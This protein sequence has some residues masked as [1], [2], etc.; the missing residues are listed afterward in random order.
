MFSSWCI[1]G[2][3]ISNWFGLDMYWSLI[4]QLETAIRITISQYIWASDWCKSNIVGY[5][6]D[7]ICFRELELLCAPTI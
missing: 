6:D 1:S 5:D 7:N 4:Q 3:F 2:R